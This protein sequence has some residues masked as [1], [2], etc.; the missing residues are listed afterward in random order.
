MLSLGTSYVTTKAVSGGD[1]FEG[2]VRLLSLRMDLSEMVSP[3]ATITWYLSSD[4]DGDDP[5]TPEFTAS[6]VGGKTTS[7][8]GA[9]CSTSLGM[10]F[11]APAAVYFWAKCNAGGAGLVTAEFFWSE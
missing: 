1:T 5:L 4:D 11:E 7:T 10:D 2:R 9:A 8:L 6:V 3:P